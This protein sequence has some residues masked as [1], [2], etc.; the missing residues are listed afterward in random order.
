MNKSNMKS[1]ILCSQVGPHVWTPRWAERSERRRNQLDR[2][3]SGHTASAWSEVAQSAGR[4]GPSA[5]SARQ[6]GVRRVAPIGAVVPETT[7]RPANSERQRSEARA[8]AG[9]CARR[10]GAPPAGTPGS[11]PQ[12]LASAASLPSAQSVVDGLDEIHVVQRRK[13]D[14][15]TV[16]ERHHWGYPLP[17]QVHL[18][19]QFLDCWLI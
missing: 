19:A 9:G 6:A 2:P 16:I 11:H 12:E 10:A 13:V 5:A 7:P 17:Q 1:N 3:D 8:A 18:D 14:V 4:R 15:E